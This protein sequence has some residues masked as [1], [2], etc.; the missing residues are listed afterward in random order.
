MTLQI[1]HLYLAL[2]T[3]LH[4]LTPGPSLNLCGKLIIAG[5]AGICKT[6]TIFII[7][8]AWLARPPQTNTT[9]RSSGCPTSDDPVELNLQTHHL[10]SLPLLP[11]TAIFVQPLNPHAWVKRKGSWDA[12]GIPSPGL[13]R[14][15]PLSE[16]INSGQRRHLLRCGVI[17]LI[18][19]LLTN[20]CTICTFY[21]ASAN[22]GVN[23]MELL[24]NGKHG[25]AAVTR[26][27]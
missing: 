17:A 2:P 10:T 18:R 4:S 22:S 23:F 3:C 27:T 25:Q 16:I 15:H 6:D 5:S 13:P 21:M 7:S 26:L 8:D 19:T 1:F 24:L 12:K 9:P 20:M 14:L 11:T